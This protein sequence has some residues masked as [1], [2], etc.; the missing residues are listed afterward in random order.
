MASSS[1]PRIFVFKAGGAIAKGKAVKAG[2]DDQ[3]VQ[4]SAAATDKS[5][6][7]MQNDA[8]NAEDPCEIALQGGGA[9]G[10]LGG[11][12]AFGDDLVPN[13]SGALIASVTAGDRPIAKAM[14]AGVSGDLIP[15]EVVIGKL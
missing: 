3:H 15:V 13:A 11:T 5:V 7:I 2:A 12:V 6:G 9:K 4:V 14:G 1:T 8:V 10:L